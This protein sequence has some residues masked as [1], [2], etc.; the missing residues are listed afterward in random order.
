MTDTKLAIRCAKNGEFDSVVGSIVL[1][2]AKDPVI[3]WFFPD[4]HRFLEAFPAVVRAVA[5]PAFESGTAH[6]LDSLLAAALW[7]PP[8]VDADGSSIRAAFEEHIQAGHLTEVLDFIRE[9]NTYHPGDEPLWY[10]HM[11]GVDPRF[12]GSGYGSAL[13]RY[14]L[15][16]VDD[17]HLAAYLESTNPAN[18]PLYMRYGFELLATVEV[19]SSPPIFPML[20]PPR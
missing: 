1:A 3:R 9:K 2:F 5:K 6:R 19:G 13:L 12:Q 16:R 11:I 17:A 10:L 7:L 15:E 20:R 4:P 8:G 14:A 18:L